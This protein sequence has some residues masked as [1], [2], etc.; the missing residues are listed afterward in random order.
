MCQGHLHIHEFTL[1]DVHTPLNVASLVGAF[2]VIVKTDCKT[3]E[4]SAALLQ[5]THH[6][7]MSHP[8]SPQ[9]HQHRL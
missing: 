5:T 3:D 8:T 6:R 2:S 7:P 1:V 4:S 9:Q